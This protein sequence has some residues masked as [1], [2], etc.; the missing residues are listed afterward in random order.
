MDMVPFQS[1]MEVCYDRRTENTDC[2]SKGRRLWVCED[3]PGSRYIRKYSEI[4]CRRK[5]LTGKAASQTMSAMTRD[6]N[7][8]CLCCGKEVAQTPGRKEKKFCSDRCRNKWWNSHLDRVKRKANYEFI[9]PQCR[10]P[11][12]AYGNA[13]RKYCSHECY[14]AHRFGGG[15]D[16]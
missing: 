9:C 14:I 7:H 15:T 8:F 11:F 1:F 12:T 4:I 6:G 10:K 13:K 3:C 16:D 2:K 5:K